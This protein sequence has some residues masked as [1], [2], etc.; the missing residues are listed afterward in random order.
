MYELLSVAKKFLENGKIPEN[1]TLCDFTMGNGHDTE[2][3]CRLAPKG[4]VYAFDIQPDAIENT[5]KRLA[6]AGLE[7]ATLILDSHSMSKTTSRKR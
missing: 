3:L 4:H 6:E 1:A 5:R 2:Y 7:N